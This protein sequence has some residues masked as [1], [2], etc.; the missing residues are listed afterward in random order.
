M[1]MPV[2][3]RDEVL[4]RVMASTITS[5]DRRI[6]SMNMPKGFRTLGRLAL[7]WR[8]PRRAVLGVEF[9]GLVHAIGE[10]VNN[11]VPGDAVF[12]ISGF[13]MGTHAGF[14]CMPAHGALALKPHT[15]SFESAASLSF[16]GTTALWFLKRAA[17]V[18]GEAILINGASGNVGAA[19]VQLACVLG[20]EV[21]G[22]CSPAHFEQVRSLGVGRVID[23]GRDDFTA[24]DH[25]FDVVFDVACNRSVEQCL[26]VLNPGGRLIRLQAGLPEMG[27]SLLQPLRGGRRVIV[28]NA[29]ER[30]LDL[31]RL[32][33]WVR[34]GHFRPVVARV[35]PFDQAIEAH[36]FAELPGCGGSVVLQME[37]P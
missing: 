25:R 17:I 19:A 20:G 11:F 12:G 21:S 27:R 16:G 18:P 15:L 33:E 13:R 32:A 36:R 29:Q 37:S 30:R 1:P 22:V 2:P 31:E 7:G 5:A 9:S 24:M 4:I 35:F 34:Q 26:S 3:K 28:G 6:R 8:G 14:L 23:Y 10:Q